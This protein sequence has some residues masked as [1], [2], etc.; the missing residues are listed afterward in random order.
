MDVTLRGLGLVAVAGLL[1][2]CGLSG[3]GGK[4]SYTGIA[5]GISAPDAISYLGQTYTVGYSAA[6]KNGVVV[7]YYP[8]GESPKQWRQMLALR[9]IDGPSTPQQQ[10]ASMAAA[11]R[12]SGSGTETST[13][14]ATHEIDFTVTKAGGPEFNLYR[15][16]PSGTAVRSVQYAAVV[17]KENLALGP[18]AMRALAAKHRKAVMQTA[19]P[20][21]NRQ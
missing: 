15:Y 2:Q 19:F 21:V 18:G 3:A 17:P 5:P 16:D 11:M 1:S 6:N 14:G 20:E 7:E 13:N 12:N 4:E 9:R 10:A 8:A